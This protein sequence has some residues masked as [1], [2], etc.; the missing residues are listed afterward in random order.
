MPAFPL[1]VRLQ[2]N[3]PPHLSLPQ[4]AA[5]KA[6]AAAAA[7]RFRAD[8]AGQL[9]EKEAARVAGLR[10]KREELVCMMAELEA[11]PAGGWGPGYWVLGLAGWLALVGGCVRCGGARHARPPSPHRQAAAALHDPKTSA[12]V[13]CACC[14]P[15]AALANPSPPLDAG[16]QEDGGGVHGR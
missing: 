15:A 11:S 13:P 1:A 5:R 10:E 12:Q 3:L 7:A 9:G 4:E 6:A 2:A 16:V 14:P 8:V